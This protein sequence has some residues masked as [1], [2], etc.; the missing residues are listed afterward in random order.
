[1]ITSLPAGC[2]LAGGVV[3]CDLGTLEPGESRVLTAEGR[4]YADLADGTVIRNCTSVY[5]TTTSPDL[6]GAQSCATTVVRRPFVP[7]T[8]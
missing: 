1:M 8:G 4:V 6:A 3:T 7:V 5:S 2:T